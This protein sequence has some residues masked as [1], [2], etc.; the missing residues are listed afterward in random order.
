MNK[1]IT[2]SKRSKIFSHF[3]HVAD[4]AVPEKHGTTVKKYRALAAQ[5]G[6]LASMPVCYRVRSGF[7]FMDH[8]MKL[9]CYYAEMSSGRSFQDDPT[10]DGLVFWCP[11]LLQ[12]SRNRFAYDQSDLLA[13]CRA[14]LE[15]SEHHLSGFG[16]I[17]LVAGLLLAH[18]QVTG[19]RVLLCDGD[20]TVRV[21]SCYTDGYHMHLGHNLR[22]D[23]V[24]CGDW[25]NDGNAFKDRGVFAL[26]VEA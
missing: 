11:R 23:R 2:M 8:A 10:S 15:L 14:R 20:H 5:H 12:G 7:T 9:G 6:V 25:D 1:G 4:A 18:R 22:T 16:S 21:D 24:F 3:T 17:A 19:E 13:D 26:G